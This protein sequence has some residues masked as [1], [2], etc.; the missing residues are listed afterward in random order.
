MKR[1]ILFLLVTLFCSG[2]LKSQD[3][4]SK[5][6]SISLLTVGPGED[7]YSFFGH[8]A[9]RV[10]DDSLRFDVVFNYG[11]F[12]FSDD[13]YVQFT[14]GKLN[15]KLSTEPFEN[16]KA[17]YIWENRWVIEQKLN[18][19]QSQKQ[20]VFE[21]LLENYK[22]ENRYYLYDFFYDNC[23][24]RP[25]DIIEY[26]LTN[27][28]ELNYTET[29][30]DSSFRDL[31]D[32]YLPQQ[33]WGDIGIDLGL[34]S[35]ADKIANAK[36]KTFLPDYLLVA[37]NNSKVLTETQEWNQLVSSS[38]QLVDQRP[39]DTPFDFLSPLMC[40]FYLALIYLIFGLFIPS[41]FVLKL[42][43]S[44]VFFGVGM[45]GWL[46]LFLWFITDHNTTQNNFNILWS[47]PLLFPLGFVIWFT[48]SKFSNLMFRLFLGLNVLLFLSW[49]LL[50]QKMNPYFL[51]FIFLLS[52]RYSNYLGIWKNGP[53][54]KYK[55]FS[56]H[57]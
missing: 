38:N 54:G 37:F 6:S 36:Q 3:S 48:P 27:E 51:L 31:I 8:T 22:P 14:M 21:A 7:L 49:F 24:T 9:I 50:P 47:I 11:T 5:K 25:R 52:L 28:I 4:L 29:E 45:A 57:K 35:P 1:I 46:I 10:K 2:H 13:F 40:F 34:G 32:V 18:F 55:L 44:L 56:L 12:E 30:P 17:G 15:Y 19:N 20:R 43:D 23:S 39:S 16:F 41:T 42:L 53:W 33:S 26:A